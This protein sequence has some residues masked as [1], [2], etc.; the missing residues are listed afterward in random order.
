[1]SAVITA[2]PLET[3]RGEER[4]QEDAGV[5]VALSGEERQP[6]G[7]LL[8]GFCRRFV[9]QQVGHPHAVVAQAL[10]QS[11]VGR[12]GHTTGRA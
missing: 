12:D 5:R 7:A 6:A 8:D 10:A 4:A 3:H 9:S 11:H 1:M 2:L